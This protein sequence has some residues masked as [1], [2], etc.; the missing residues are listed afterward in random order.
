MNA[1]H[2]GSRQ[3]MDATLTEFFGCQR[4]QRRGSTVQII[5]SA[6]RTKILPS[7]SAT[8]TASVKT[9]AALEETRAL[10]CCD[11]RHV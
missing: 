9:P 3:Q 6:A 1:R 11:A 5:M 7:P 10:V 2:G 8:S 4:E